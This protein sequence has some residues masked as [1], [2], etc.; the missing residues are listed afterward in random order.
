MVAST[1]VQVPADESTKGRDDDEPI[2]FEVILPKRSW[3]QPADKDSPEK[4]SLGLR[5]TNR[6]KDNVLV[7][8]YM[9]IAIAL[10]DADGVELES[11]G[12]AMGLMAPKLA[13]YRMLAPDESTTFQL[14]AGLAITDRE[15]LWFGGKDGYGAIWGFYLPGSGAYSLQ[16]SYSFTPEKDVHVRERNGISLHVPLDQIVPLTYRSKFVPVAFGNPKHEQDGARQ[17][18]T[19]P[20]S[21]SEGNEK[22]NPESEGRSQ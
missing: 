9:T 5:L 13:D 2:Q 11:A 12:Y 16:I 6:S 18:A 15:S 1:I 14:S 8:R 21:K 4:I 10:K 20:D 19:A 7:S 3:I 17:P 22:L